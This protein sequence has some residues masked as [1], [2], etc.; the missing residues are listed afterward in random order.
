MKLFAFAPILFALSH[1][2]PVAQ[3]ASESQ[4]EPQRCPG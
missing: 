4:P 2:A 3:P 1:A